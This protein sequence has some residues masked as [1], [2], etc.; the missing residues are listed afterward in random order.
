MLGGGLGL[1]LASLVTAAAT[2]T[3]GVGYWQ[4]IK[5][6]FKTS[7]KFTVSLE[8]PQSSQYFLELLAYVKEKQLAKE[9]PQ[10]VALDENVAAG[11]SA[12]SSYYGYPNYRNG[13]K[14]KSTQQ[15]NSEKPMF[16]PAAG[17][18]EFQ[19]VCVNRQF[20]YRISFAA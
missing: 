11:T 5:H 18:Y 12:L 16:V 6:A 9:K 14:V 8:I 4:K 3:Y 2:L 1:G 17:I 13:G 7:K 15:T 10:H 20:K 19:Y